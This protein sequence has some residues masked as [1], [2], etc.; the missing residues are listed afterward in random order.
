MFSAEDRKFLEGDSFKSGRKFRF[1]GKGQAETR[2]AYI[3]SR[4]QG[5]KIIH[6]GFA[7]H[8]AGMIKAK[9]KEGKWL[10]QAM[11]DV[12]DRC[13]GIDINSAA[14][15]F[16]RTELGI[17]DLHCADLLEDEIPGLEE[18]NWDYMI[19]GEI[20]EH[21][22]DPVH[23]L[24]RIRE[25]YAQRVK[26]MIITVP[27]ALY[28]KNFKLGWKGI[29]EINTDH[30]YWFTPYTLAKVMTRAGLHVEDLCCTQDFSLPFSPDISWFILKHKPVLRSKVVACGLLA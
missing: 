6:V 24:S 18:E 20:L 13:M 9:L 12:A 29:E 22:D 11:L 1:G 7:D 10:H 17:A 8:S 19:L 30:R 14:T 25:R 15:E 5:K 21:V 28:Y 3:L 23:F 2:F 27:N 16:A 4:I 26:R